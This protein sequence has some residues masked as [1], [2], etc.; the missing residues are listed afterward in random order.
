MNGSPTSSS[1]RSQIARA[2]IILGDPVEE[3]TE[4][5]PLAQERIRDGVESRV[6][7]A[8]TQGAVVRVGGSRHGDEGWFFQPTVLDGVSNDMEVSRN[9]LFGPVLAVLRFDDQDEAIALAND[10]PF[11]L[12]AG[13]WTSNLSRAHAVA[14]RL[15]AGTVWV[16]TYRTLSYASPFGG[17]KASGYGRE[18]GLEGFLEFTQPKSVWIETA[19]EVIGDPFVL[20]T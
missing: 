13:I 4:M 14:A 9:E 2:S 5:G 6:A 18:N 19:D 11:G 20:R 1:M 16:N 8:V 17:R 7:E 12:A 3:S 15:D 10:S